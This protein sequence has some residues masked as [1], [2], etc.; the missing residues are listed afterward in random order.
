MSGLPPE[1]VREADLAW[2]LKRVRRDHCEVICAMSLYRGNNGNADTTPS[3]LACGERGACFKTP[4]VRVEPPTE[5]E[6]T[7]SRDACAVFGLRFARGRV[8]RRRGDG[9]SVAMTE[10]AVVIVGAGPTGLILAGECGGWAAFKR[11]S[12][13]GGAPSRGQQ[14]GG[15]TEPRGCY[16]AVALRRPPEAARCRVE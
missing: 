4:G 7:G 8:G 5:T 6:P 9:W 10:H 13:K 3:I 16:R 11:A 14:G 2:R 12:G 1:A 15:A